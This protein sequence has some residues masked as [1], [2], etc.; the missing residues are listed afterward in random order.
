MPLVINGFDL[1]DFD[2]E[3]PNEIKEQSPT[4][5]CFVCNIIENIYFQMAIVSALTIGYILLFKS[6]KVKK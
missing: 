3:F 2:K 5:K 6:S 4:E 1:K